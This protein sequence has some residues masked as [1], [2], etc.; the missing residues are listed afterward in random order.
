MLSIFLNSW[1]IIVTVGLPGACEK[2]AKWQGSLILYN[3]MEELRMKPDTRNCIEGRSLLKKK[4]DVVGVFFVDTFCQKQFGR[5]QKNTKQMRSKI[6]HGPLS[7]RSRW[8]VMGSPW[9]CPMA[10]GWVITGFFSAP[11][12]EFWGRSFCKWFFFG[13][14]FVDSLCFLVGK[15]MYPPEI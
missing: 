12:M 5:Q 9:K 11:E 2:A 14:H 8:S 3:N 6:H 1:V 15:W 13:V 10:N 4:Q 7:L